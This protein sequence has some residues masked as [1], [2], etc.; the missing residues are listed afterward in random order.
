MLHPLYVLNWRQKLAIS[1]IVSARRTLNPRINYARNTRQ[2]TGQQLRDYC[3]AKH[4]DLVTEVVEMPPDSAF[5]PAHLHFVPLPSPVDGGPTVVYVHGGGYLFPMIGDCHIPLA[6][7]AAQS[8]KAKTLVFL[9]YTLSA[10][11]EFPVQLAQIAQSVVLLFQRGVRPSE[12]IFAGDSAG[13]HLIA[14][15]M[16]HIS[17]PCPSVPPVDLRGQQIG[18]AILLSP[19]LDMVPRDAYGMENEAHDILTQNQLH[20]MAELFETKSDSPWAEPLVAKDGKTLCVKAFSKAG[21]SQSVVAKTLVTA[22]E[23]EVLFKS[24]EQFAQDCIGA[25]T[26]IM[27]DSGKSK[28]RTVVDEEAPV[29]A[30]GVGEVHVQPA[31]DIAVGYFGGG[32]MAALTAFLEAL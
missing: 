5:P 12:L 13:G 22:G 31:I 9:E 11:R 26:V 7:H 10:E 24:C 30:V 29:F 20:D 18:A 21:G 17:Q 16:L 15:L 19:W 27:D 23:R 1:V 14:S 25:A 2:T 28:I 32:T 3:T 8:C 4:I 6:L